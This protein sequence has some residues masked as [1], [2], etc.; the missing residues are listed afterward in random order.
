MRQVSRN[1]SKQRMQISCVSTKR[2]AK[3]SRSL[4][5]TT[6]IPYVSLLLNPSPCKYVALIGH[7]LAMDSIVTGEFT[8]RKDKRESQSF[9][10]SNRST[11]SKVF[12]RLN[13]TFHRRIQRGGSSRWSLRRV[14]SLRLVSSEFQSEFLRVVLSRN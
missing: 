7:L 14:T 1:T 6:V 12:Q 5:S 4:R 10:K 9:R 11:S 2:N 3:L 13:P 8:T